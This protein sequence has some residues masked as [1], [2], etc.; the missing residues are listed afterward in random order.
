MSLNVHSVVLSFVVAT[1]ALVGCDRDDHGH[2]HDAPKPQ[3]TTTP[4]VGG[5]AQPMADDHDNT[6]SSTQ[7]KLGDVT[8]AGYTF[9][10]TQTSAITPGKEADITLVQ[11]AGTGEPKA[12]RI[13]IGNESGEGSVKVRTH[14]HGS[15]M[16]AHVE[17]PDP[18]A[19]DAKL[20]VEVETADAKQASSV[21]IKR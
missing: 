9:T 8:V 1:A 18:L 6:G 7:H 11:T 13:W 20:W 3:S 2:P 14:K 10:V 19:A 17:V 15:K 5:D 16:E 12:V 21:A 4:A